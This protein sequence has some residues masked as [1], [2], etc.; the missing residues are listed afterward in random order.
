MRTAK[1][2]TSLP[3]R[4]FRPELRR[5]PHCRWQLK[6]CGT[7]WRK[8]LVTLKGR[9]H[10]VSQSYR[11]SNPAC[12][13]PEIRYRSAEAETLSLPGGSFGI[14]VIVEIGYRRF[15][16]RQTVLEIHAALKDSIP[17]SER[18]VLNLIGDFLALLRA[19]Q[20]AK[21]AQLLP[22]LKEL[23]GMILAI[24]GMQPEKGNDALYIVREAQLDLTLAAEVLDHG[25]HDTLQVKLLKPIKAWGIP[26]G[27]V[28]SDAQESIRLAVE[29]TLPGVAHQ[30]CQFH[31]IREAGRLTFLADRAMKTDLKIQLRGRI[32]RARATICAL[33]NDDPYR[34]TLLAYANHIRSTLQEGGI[35][36]FDL[37]GIR[38]YQDLAAIE[39]SLR[40]AREKGGIVSWTNCSRQWRC[41]SRLPPSMPVW[42]VS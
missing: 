23:G 13:R 20:P 42:N 31:A 21:I 35:P 10:V 9:E 3:K 18:H 32:H 37:G 11:C 27:G 38:M 29:Q 17:I 26:I 4:Y 5:C 28:I 1:N 25:D 19:G 41:A 7:L 2:V 34:P 16:M 15:W 30:N 40:R 6:R 33:P 14:N 12:P 8:N 39:A 22:K 24:D 36:P